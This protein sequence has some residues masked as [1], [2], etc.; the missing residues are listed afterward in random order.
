MEEKVN[1]ESEETNL[2]KARKEKR[3]GRN[4]D[5]NPVPRFRRWQKRAVCCIPDQSS[6]LNSNI[7]QHRFMNRLSFFFQIFL[8]VLS[9]SSLNVL[10][11]F[12]DNCRFFQIS[13]Q[14]C[15][16]GLLTPHFNG[17][18]CILINISQISPGKFC[19]ATTFDVS[20][21]CKIILQIRQC[22]CNN[23]FYF[24]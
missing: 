7:I 5:Q 19:M 14:K 22:N 10:K 3:K 1:V 8:T 6:F 20:E 17:L 23:A 21:W 11:I 4:D 16:T 2:K 9:C 24:L 13:T 18:I 15:F 12:N